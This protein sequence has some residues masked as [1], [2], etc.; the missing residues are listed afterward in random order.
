MSTRKRRDSAI[1]RAKTKTF[2]YDVARHLRTP[3]EMAEYLDAWVED[4]PDDAAGIARAISDVARALGIL[5][6][7][8][9]TGLSRERL[10]KALGGN[11]DVRLTAVLRVA[12][13]L[14]PK[15]RTETA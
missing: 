8:R 9:E 15:L 1:A 5:E 7:A 4:A 10:F 12:H 11:G 14:R 3:V 13:A 2:P 6:I